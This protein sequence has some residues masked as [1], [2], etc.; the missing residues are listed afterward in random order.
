MPHIV[1]EYSRNLHVSV[2]ESHLLKELHQV[3]IA[4]G[5]FSPQ[6]VKA[7]G[8]A[9]DDYILTGDDDSFVHINI[10]ILG[11]R[12]LDAR[13][14]LMESVYAMASGLL[15]HADKISL[16]IHEMDAETYKK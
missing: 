1:V 2:Q 6:A 3:V 10:A 15:P 14:A 5:L 16:N 11:G 7:R 8:M 13:K 4:S 9:Y 12:P